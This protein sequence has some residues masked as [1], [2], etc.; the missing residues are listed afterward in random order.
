LKKE[1]SFEVYF[2]LLDEVLIAIAVAV[3]L[4][5]FLKGYGVVGWGLFI[6]ILVSIILIGGLLS[7]AILKAYRKKPQVGKEALIGAIGEALSDIN[8]EGFVLVEGEI[9]RARSISGEKIRKGEKVKVVSVEGLTLIVKPE[10]E[11]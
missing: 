4:L 6:G 2:A 7:L 11:V 9:W 10:K 3:V 8:D 5:A 1:I